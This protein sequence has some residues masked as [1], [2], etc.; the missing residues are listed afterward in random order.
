MEQQ[1]PVV[2][3]FAQ[4]R[5]PSGLAFQVRRDPPGVLTV[6]PIDK[7]LLSVHIGS[8]TKVD[9]HRAGRHFSG[10]A[11]HGDIDIIPAGTAAR[12]ELVGE[13]D[14][15]VLI[16]LPQSLLDIAVSE[17]VCPALEVLNRFQ[18]RDPVLEA[19][20][21]A[22]A[23]EI[24]DGCPSGGAYLDGIGLAVSS[25]LLTHHTGLVPGADE[26]DGL[27]G[28][29]LKRVLSYIEDRLGAEMSLTDIAA[30]AGLS[31]SHLTTLFRKSMGLSVH[32]HVI[33]RRVERAKAMLQEGTLPIAEV[34][35]AV[36]F[37]HQSHMSR[38]MVRVLG[39]RPL[40]IR[41]VAQGGNRR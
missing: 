21:V 32:Q 23:R 11:V 3:I 33:R 15:A 2:E 26:V 30:S 40:Q 22:A 20:A 35:L 13:E 24:E 9:C 31:A 6:P 17:M 37:S 14:R 12:W 8:P 28:H 25:R 41:Q 36:G 1:A 10:T 7:T 19:L 38:H 29:R 16:I 34:A 18:I 39:M 5:R 27:S 4:A